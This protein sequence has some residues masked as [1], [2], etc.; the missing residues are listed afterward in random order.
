MRRNKLCNKLSIKTSEG[1]GRI[2][3][4]ALQLNRLFLDAYAVIDLAVHEERGAGFSREMKIDAAE[5]IVEV[6]FE[7]YV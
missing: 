3:S 7:E 2:I 6:V 4:R 1:L 5:F